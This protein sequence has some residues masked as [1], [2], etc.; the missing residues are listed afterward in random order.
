MKKIKSNSGITLPF[1]VMIVFLISLLVSALVGM[2]TLTVKVNASIHKE[3]EHKL[4]LENIMYDYLNDFDEESK[5]STVLDSYLIDIN[6]IDDNEYDIDDNE[7]DIELK[8]TDKYKNIV[9]KVTVKFDGANYTI[10]KWGFA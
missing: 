1:T 3:V 8:S 10:K 7:Y 5:M 6:T 4:I 9:L 2:I